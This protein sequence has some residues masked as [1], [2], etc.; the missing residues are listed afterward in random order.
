MELLNNLL[1]IAALLL[2]GSIVVSSI[3]ARVGAPLLLI[4]LIVGMLAGEEGP[5]N[6]VFDD[7]GTAY[8][9]GSVALG[10]I[11][12]N[13]GLHTKVESFRVGLRPALT[14]ATVGVLITSALVGLLAAWVFDLHWLQGLLLGAIIGSTDAAAVFSLLHARG[15][16]IERRVGATLEIESGS[17]DPMAVFL[18][19]ML[20]E[21]LL[22]Q[23]SLFAWNTLLL[24]AIQMGIG[25]V[26]GILGARLLVYMVNHLSLAN[27]LYPLLVTSGGLLIFA[28]AN[29]LGGSGFLA[30]YLLGV[31]LGNRKLHAG[32]NILR[33]HDGLAW[34][35]Q[36]GMFLILGLLVTPSELL[37][38]AGD[39]LL[40]ALA[41]IFVAR[42]L[43]VLVCLA[44]Y[45]FVWREQLY[46]AW[47]GL[48][49][50][51]PIILALFPLLAGLEQAELYFNVA[52]F[53]VLVSLLMQGWTVAPV[54]R[55]LRLE[56]PPGPEPV[57]QIDTL[58]PGHPECEI[59][60]YKLG[61]TSPLRN[62]SPDYF[63]LPGTARLTS[64]IRHG[65]SYDAND[66]ERFEPGD[67]LHILAASN[68]VEQINRL[69]TTLEYAA[70]HQ[71]FGDF[72]LEP[73]AR[74]C[75]LSTAYGVPVPHACDTLSVGEYLT[76]QFHNK[77]V[78]G[79]RVKL[80]K[81]E[82]VVLEMEAGQIVK[83]GLKITG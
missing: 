24:F 44:P 29:S 36:I 13:G 28:L 80:D 23:G 20:I 54:A 45:R 2:F 38:L 49:G 73:S 57:M 11:L 16:N 82:L 67:Y 37:P 59:L 53:V 41:L 15:M 64:V 4:F 17:N 25:A 34:L 32:Q 71:F 61:S 5:G 66:I 78:V 21:I 75:D 30:I 1:L 63:V 14:L 7:V 76:Q 3:S 69:F 56:I 26:A 58:I 40:I 55:L 70:D 77:P 18:T 52:F 65:I 10:I 51:V 9:I 46:I 48:R 68:E 79:D 47:V 33:V 50:A 81:I 74:L 22:T 31:G 35:S 8:L 43:A 62:R 60:V 19:I 12:L 42:P 83:I 39:A 27:G 72:I 6:L